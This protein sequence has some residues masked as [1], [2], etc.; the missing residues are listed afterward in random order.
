MLH[1]SKTIISVLDAAV[2]DVDSNYTM[3][4]GKSILGGLKSH[5]ML[6]SILGILVLI[7]FKIDYCQ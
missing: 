5:V 2:F 3:R 7:P 6:L 4:I 1:N